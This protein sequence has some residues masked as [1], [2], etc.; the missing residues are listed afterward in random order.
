MTEGII[1]LLGCFNDEKG[2]LIP[3]ATA[4]ADKAFE[5]WQK[6]KDFLILPTGGFG[7][8]NKTAKPHGDYYK[9]YLMK[10]GMP[11]GSFLPTILSHNT[12]T[13]ATLS[14]ELVKKLEP[15]KLFLVSSWAHLPRASLIFR[16]VYRQP[17]HLIGSKTLGLIKYPAKGILNELVGA[18]KVLVGI[19]KIPK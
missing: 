13:D 10:K 6:H 17:I 15:K 18:F 4:R 11:E 12:I 14:Y 5:V 9:E 2:N 16:K 1:I 3:M 19:I 8:F 7:Y